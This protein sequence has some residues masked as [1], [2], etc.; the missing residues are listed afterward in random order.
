VL[1]G[2]PIW[3]QVFSL[4][5]GGYV[6]PLPDLRTADAKAIQMFCKDLENDDFIDGAT[7]AVFF[8]MVVLSPSEHHFAIVTLV[9][10]CSPMACVAPASVLTR[11]GLSSAP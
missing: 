5:G 2:V 3:G 8:E 11:C 6:A 10:C 7:R 4:S 1:G 9:P